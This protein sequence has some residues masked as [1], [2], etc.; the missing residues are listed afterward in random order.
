ML[1]FQSVSA[2]SSAIVLVFCAADVILLIVLC[3]PHNCRNARSYSG[4]D[5]QG[6][7]E[8]RLVQDT[9]T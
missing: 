5:E 3:S 4:F 8:D 7:G 6:T 2:V 1:H 9:C